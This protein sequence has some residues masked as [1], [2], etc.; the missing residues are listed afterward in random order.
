[1]HPYSRDAYLMH[2]LLVVSIDMQPREGTP[3]DEGE[4]SA[5]QLRELR[6]SGSRLAG[7]L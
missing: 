2:V 7:T 3:I 5:E 4:A 6:T 1:M